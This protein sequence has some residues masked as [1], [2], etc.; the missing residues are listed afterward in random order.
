M[1]WEMP[2]QGGEH[3]HGSSV[4]AVLGAVEGSRNGPCLLPEAS[5]L[6]QPCPGFAEPMCP[7]IFILLV[8]LT[9]VS[10]IP[11][12]PWQRGRRD[13]CWRSCSSV[14]GSEPWFDLSSACAALAAA[15]WAPDMVTLGR[16][17]HGLALRWLGATT[18]RCATWS[19]PRR[20]C[21]AGQGLKVLL[22]MPIPCGM[23]GT[24]T[25]NPHLGRGS[26]LL[27]GQRGA[28]VTEMSLKR[29]AEMLD[30]LWGRP[31]TWMSRMSCL[32]FIRAC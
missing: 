21:R 7:P 16:K 25:P 30:A 17:W 15:G 23:A 10:A 27:A 18:G 20:V 11:G 26:F 9:S 13:G 3:G 1:G 5:Q 2:R 24:G 4:R 22:V 32:P 12:M 31:S 14:Q 6:P 8:F 19:S 28:E 29:A